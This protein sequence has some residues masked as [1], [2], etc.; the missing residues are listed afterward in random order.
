MRSIG[1]VNIKKL[2]KIVLEE[3]LKMHPY[4][5]NHAQCINNIEARIPEGWHDIHE[6]AW[7]EIARLTSDALTKLIYQR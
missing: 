4:N 3:Y 2:N 5:F 6:S 7:S 1:K